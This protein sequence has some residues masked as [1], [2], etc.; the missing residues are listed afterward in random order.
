M[1]ALPR[2]VSTAPEWELKFRDD[3]A[4]DVATERRLLIR[5][6]WTIAAFAGLVLLRLVLS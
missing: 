3:L 2:C 6:L 1:K 5:E 4:A